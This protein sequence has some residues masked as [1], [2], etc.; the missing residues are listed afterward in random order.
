MTDSAN[1]IAGFIAN[2]AMSRYELPL[3][4]VHLFDWNPSVLDD[5]YEL[6]WA[7]SLDSGLASL[8]SPCKEE[9]KERRSSLIQLFCNGFAKTVEAQGRKGLSLLQENLN[10]RFEEEER[11]LNRYETIE[12]YRCLLINAMC[13]PLIEQG[14][15][16]I[17]WKPIDPREEVICPH[18]EPPEGF[19]LDFY[20][21]TCGYYGLQVR[22]SY[23][24]L[25]QYRINADILPARVTKITSEPVGD[26]QMTYSFISHCIKKRFAPY[27]RAKRSAEEVCTLLRFRSALLKQYMWAYDVYG[28]V[29]NLA[30]T[31]VVPDRIASCPARVRHAVTAVRVLKR[32]YQ[33]DAT[34]NSQADLRREIEKRTT[35]EERGASAE[36]VVKG[37]KRLVGNL[38]GT[39]TEGASLVK[40]LWSNRERV[41]LYAD[42]MGLTPTNGNR[43]SR[44]NTL[45]PGQKNDE[46]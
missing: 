15:V 7:H 25:E 27:I 22:V 26:E 12:R 39:E 24:K 36:A 29:P 9:W 8:S 16:E 3:A 6:H 43:L 20:E 38:P 11:R 13:K 21:I 17:E 46:L 4:P 19:T 28:E 33:D 35:I 34:V 14:D 10:R 23:E 40:C 30:D 45:S 32:C 2:E 18:P 31:V 42:E 5:G 44:N 1:G 37:T 41:F